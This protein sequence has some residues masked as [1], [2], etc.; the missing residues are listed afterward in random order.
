MP[1]YELFGDNPQTIDRLGFQPMA[2]ILVDVIQQTT[3]PFT[4]GI[5]G[6]WGS[7]KT[8]LMTLT[9]RQ[10]DERSAK[11][12]WFNAWKYDGKE[13]IWNAL[14][15]TIFLA[16]K[17]N[18]PTAPKPGFGERVRD[19]AGKLAVF[20]AKK[21]TEF[22]PGGIVK[23]EDV[24]TVLEAFRPFSANDPQFDFINKFEATFDDLVKEYVGDDGRLVVFVDDLDRCLPENAIQ[25]LEAIKLYL[26]RA[27][28]TFVI[29]AERAIIEQG[30]RERYKE[31]GLC[32]IVR[33]L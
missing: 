24:D 4:I 14:I 31:N 16:M 20:A 25:V 27:N 13:L 7:G 9:R 32:T 6:E 1:T 29:G 18:A 10:L 23:P 2:D 3:P 26:D 30:I 28:V 15:Q 5:F 17:S 12:V 19:T 22:I 21:A 11:T 8:T 33:C